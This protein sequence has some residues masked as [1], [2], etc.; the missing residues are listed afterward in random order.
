[1]FTRYAGGQASQAASSEDTLIMAAQKGDVQAFNQLILSYQDRIFNLA[2]RIMGDTNLA[3]DIT[4]NTF[5]SAYL[6]LRNFR[7]GSFRSWLYRIATNACYDEYRRRKTHTV[8]SIDDQ[9]VPEERLSPIADFSASSV[10]PE[11]ENDRRELERV[12]QSALNQLEPQQRMV[13]VLVDQQE[14]DY[15]ESAQILGIPVGT[16]K[17]RLARARS[18]LRK[19][20]SNSDVIP[21]KYQYST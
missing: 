17:S 19:L 3:D 15:R 1:M 6:N 20:L 11:T 16:V 14:L 8:L 4:Q 9:E 5:L 18:Q 10:L 12:I 21:A 13:V 7:N 2:M